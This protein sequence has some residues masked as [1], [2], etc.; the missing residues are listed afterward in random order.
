[1]QL[2]RSLALSGD[3]HSGIDAVEHSSVATDDSWEDVTIAIVDCDSSVATD[4]FA[5]NIFH[6]S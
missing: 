4:E 2:G 5:S 6:A 3:A 1:M